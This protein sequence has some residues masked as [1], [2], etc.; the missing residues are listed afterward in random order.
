MMRQPFSYV[1]ETSKS[2]A[3]DDDIV[4]VERRNERFLLIRLRIYQ[5]VE[6]NPL[7]LH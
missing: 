3:D 4:Q 6:G 1:K 7:E 2:A 5:D